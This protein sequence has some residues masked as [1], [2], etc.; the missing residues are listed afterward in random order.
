MQERIE[1]LQGENED[2]RAAMGLSINI[3]TLISFLFSKRS[4]LPVTSCNQIAGD[5]QAVCAGMY[6]SSV[7]LRIDRRSFCACKVCL[8]KR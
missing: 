3:Q 7:Y 6:R 8:R 2:Y 4:H 1:S 5:N